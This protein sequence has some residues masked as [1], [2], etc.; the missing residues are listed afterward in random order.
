MVLGLRSLQGAPRTF[1]HPISQ[2]YSL[3]Y[4]L[5]LK[6]PYTCYGSVVCDS[7]VLDLGAQLNTLGN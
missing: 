6:Y 2:F 1:E 7:S 3:P 5:T 4:H